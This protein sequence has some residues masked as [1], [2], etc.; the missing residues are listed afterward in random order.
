M[1]KD[2]TVKL[3]EHIIKNKYFDWM[4]DGKNKQCDIIFHADGTL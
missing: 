2:P 4:H 3:K 1:F